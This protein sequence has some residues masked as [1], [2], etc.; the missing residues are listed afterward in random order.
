MLLKETK[1]RNGTRHHAFVGSLLSK[2]HQDK[3][4]FFNYLRQGTG[5]CVGELEGVF[6]GIGELGLV[7]GCYELM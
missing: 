7:V 3:S 5:D 6:V 1:E 4:Q 2:H